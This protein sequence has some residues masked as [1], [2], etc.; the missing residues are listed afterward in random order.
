MRKYSSSAPPGVRP[1]VCILGGQS[2]TFGKLMLMLMAYRLM[3][4][5]DGGAP[6]LMKEEG[7]A[8]PRRNRCPQRQHDGLLGICE[9]GIASRQQIAQK[10]IELSCLQNYRAR[11]RILPG[12]RRRGIAEHQEDRRE[13]GDLQDGQVLGRA[14]TGRTGE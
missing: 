5:S 11:V 2:A 6:D 7:V 10:L 12:R 14:Q 4:Q 13:L 3:S 8:L 1:N 9:H